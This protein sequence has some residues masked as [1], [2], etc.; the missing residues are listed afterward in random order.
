MRLVN[1]TIEPAES[2]G[3][4]GFVVILLEETRIV[5]TQVGMAA[6]FLAMLGA[7]LLNFG[8]RV[9]PFADYAVLTGSMNPAIPVGAL[10]IVMPA[11]PSQL[12][13]GDV[14]TYQRP[15][16]PGAMVTH[17]I[18]SIEVQEDGTRVFMTKGDANPSPDPY[19][20]NL[21]G[22]GWKVA[23]AIPFLGYLTV[24][25]ASWWGR[26]LLVTLPALLLCLLLLRDLWKPAKPT[27]KS[28]KPTEKG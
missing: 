21:G 10:V 18:Y 1:P 13:V 17:R 12:A 26:L 19:H 15:D 4:A 20:L 8:P 6:L 25:S 9:L 7:L 3:S 14:I 16:R 22:K 27:E 28:A 2:K 24:Y 5:L 11:K 23:Y